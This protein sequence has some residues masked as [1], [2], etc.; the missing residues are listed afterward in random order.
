MLIYYQESVKLKHKDLRQRQI[1][2]SKQNFFE[3]G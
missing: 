1:R 3:A 2:T